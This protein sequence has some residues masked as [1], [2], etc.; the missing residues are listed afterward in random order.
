MLHGDHWAALYLDDEAVIEELKRLVAQ[1]RLADLQPEQ[2]AGKTEYRY[3]VGSDGPLT[4]VAI[5]QFGESENTVE[6]AFP[7]MLDMAECE[8]EILSTAAIADENS[9]NLE[10]LVTA[11]T[12][13][14]EE[15]T[16]FCP[17]WLAL[18]ESLEAG[19][20]F[21]FRLG[22]I[23]YSLEAAPKEIVLT[24]GTLFES[25]KRR[26]SREDPEFDAAA[27]SSV[28]I[29]TSQLR[30]LFA[31]E[32]GDIEFQT[33]VE[34]VSAFQS[35]NT[36]GFIMLVNFA[37][38]GRQKIEVKL[39]ATA[40]VLNGYAPVKGDSVRGVAWLQ[41]MP[42][43]RIAAEDSW[44]DS[45]EAAHRGGS[46]AFFAMA[47]FAFGNPH[48][49]VALQAVGGAIARA[50]WDLQAIEDK[51]FRGWAPSFVAQRK[52]AEVWF[53]I[54]TEIKG[55]C[56]A[57]PF[58]ADRARC[59]T[60][61]AERNIRCLWVTV[62]LDPIGRN[63][64]IS[65]EGLEEFADELR[66]PLE[67]ARPEHFRV[68][69]LGAAEDGPEPCLD[70][71]VAADVFKS[72]LNEMNLNAF[73]KLLVED[74][75]Y[76][77]DAA[78]VRILGRQRYLTYMGGRLDE[79]SKKGTP[80]CARADRVLLDGEQRSCVTTFNEGQEVART[81]FTARKGHIAAIHTFPPASTDE[82]G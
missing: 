75:T 5:V 76:T 7:T 16:F 42:L 60:Y 72:C 45:S 65:S 71:V 10:G 58:E 29:D 26:C 66:L 53:F 61:T 28:S 81:V 17:A 20:R 50:G 23:A 70:E 48:L 9:Q 51:L 19:G 3:L 52:D 33:V 49:P 14:G 40:K 13:D 39:Y 25:E 68:L 55:F 21:K 74:L 24:E 82:A 67:L 44:L 4:G 38:E 78:S 11:I 30:S 18:R 64:A 37:P 62:Q 15:V 1:G 77:S 47:D 79:Q 54:R 69:D 63:Y 46:E 8:L 27:F 34:E 35:S 73:S 22:A 6:R 36:S 2:S 59:E 80:F 43:D 41:G 57:G 56:E 31:R 12:R 32:D